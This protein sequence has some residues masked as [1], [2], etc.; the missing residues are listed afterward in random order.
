MEPNLKPKFT[1]NN[2]IPVYYSTF[3]L[4]KQCL[5]LPKKKI[6]KLASAIDSSNFFNDV[7]S[8]TVQ[9][10]SQENAINYF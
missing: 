7:L 8:S 2:Q 9:L 4:Y 10:T 3:K 5:N 6:L 1:G